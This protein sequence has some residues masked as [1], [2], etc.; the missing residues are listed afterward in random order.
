M[1]FDEKCNTCYIGGFC[2]GGCVLERKAY[3]NEL[4]DREKS[5][6]NDFV[7]S[8]LI[9]FVMGKIQESNKFRKLANEV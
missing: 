2:S 9:P 1:F 7:E 3:K 6:F 4:C 8:L 5:N